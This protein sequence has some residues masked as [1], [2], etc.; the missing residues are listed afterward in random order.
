MIEF[1]GKTYPISQLFKNL[2]ESEGGNVSSGC[3][4]VVRT[5]PNRFV[6][7]RLVPVKERNMNNISI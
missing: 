2:G 6:F 4:T 1:D 3:S 7:K 5:I